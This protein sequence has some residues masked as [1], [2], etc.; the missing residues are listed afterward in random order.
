VNTR[1]KD[2]QTPLHV[3]SYLGNLE[4]VR[5]LLDHGAELEANCDVG[6][7]P[8]H[9]VSCGAYK[10]QVDG[11]RTAQLLLKRG[12]NVNTRRHDR[13]TPLNVASR[14]GMFEIVR[15]LIDHGAEVDAADHFGKT[16]LYQVSR[17][18]YEP[19]EDNR[20]RVAQL[21][22]NHGADVNAMDKSGVTPLALV[23]RNER[24]QLAELLLEHAANAT[25]R[26]NRASH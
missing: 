26:T 4:I 25:E 19:Q 13:S 23:S 22:L 2:Q 3:A 24:S 1:R 8:L 15:L 20:V 16:P 10:S 6:E 11:V 18:N 9:F 5:L 7:K 17:A 12:A 14:F 21:L